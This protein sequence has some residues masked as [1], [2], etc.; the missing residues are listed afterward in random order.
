M[1]HASNRSAFGWVLFII[2]IFLAVPAYGESCDKSQVQFKDGLLSVQSNG[3]SLQQVLQAVQDTAGIEMEIPASAAQI[4]I[5]ASFGPSEPATVITSL[6]AGTKFNYFMVGGDRGP[7]ERVIVSEVSVAATVPAPIQKMAPPPPIVATVDDTNAA[8]QNK[9]KGEKKKK[10][11]E[12][13][14]TENEV[15]VNNDETSQ[16]KAEVDDATI[17]KL[18]QLPPGIPAEMWRLYPDI[19]NNGGVVPSGPPTLPGGVPLAQP[20]P[21]SSGQPGTPAISNYPQ[22]PPPLPKGVVGMPT[23]PPG[24]D[25]NMGMIYPWNLMQTI[26]GPITYPSFVLPPMAL[27]IGVA[28]TPHP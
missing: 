22:D 19:A 11:Q 8:D 23:L 16:T 25:P 7:V 26:P 1:H 4:P 2:L 27:P 21:S 10:K 13:K 28:P 9:T 6:L 17:A 18:P 3:C 24:I 15:A 12:S 14:I 5:N 20:A